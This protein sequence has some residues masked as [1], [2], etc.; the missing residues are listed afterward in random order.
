MPASATVSPSSKHAWYEGEAALHPFDGETEPQYTDFQDEGKYSWVKAP[1]FYGQR[2][3]V[4]PFTDVLVGVAVGNERYTRYLNE[5]IGTIKA[6]SGLSEVPL[7]ALESMHRPATPPARYAAP[8]MIDTLGPV[9]KLV[10]NIGTG[11]V[12][13][14]NAPVF[15]KGRDQGVG[16][17]TAPRGTLSHWVVIEDAKIQN[18]QAV[19]PGTWNAGPRDATASPGPTRSSLLDNPVADPEPAAR[20]C[21]RCALSTPVSPVRSTLFDN[22]QTEIVKVKAL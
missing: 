10:D 3:E 9:A 19:V 1:T 11:D 21:A 14:F 22:E 5:A 2:A 13:T 20:Y 16:F 12:D 8:V 7:S 4:G 15:P 17:H 6:V 18:Y